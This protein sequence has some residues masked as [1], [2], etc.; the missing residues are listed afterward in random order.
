MAEVN[1]NTTKNTGYLFPNEKKNDRQP[2]FRGKATIEGKEF[3]IS[4]W[5]RDKDGAEI[6]SLSITD[7]S[8][9]PPVGQTQN[10]PASQPKN[11]PGKS[12]PHPEVN[13]NKNKNQDQGAFPDPDFFSDIFDQ[14]K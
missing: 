5:K 7:P 1:K 12:D 11:D 10:Q 3:L 8:T 4:A 6:L 2:D 13:K 14:P 9:L